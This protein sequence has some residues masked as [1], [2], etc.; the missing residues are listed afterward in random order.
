MLNFPKR[1]LPPHTL[2]GS[3]NYLHTQTVSHGNWHRQPGKRKDLQS[4]YSDR[5][6]MRTNDPCYQ[7]IDV[8][9]ISPYLKPAHLLVFWV[10]DAVIFYCLPKILY[11]PTTLCDFNNGAQTVFLKSSIQTGGNYKNKQ[12]KLL[13]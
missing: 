1:T 8:K 10:L 4:S 9:P 2:I 5:C 12:L 6:Y 7:K 13:A 11:T 3:K